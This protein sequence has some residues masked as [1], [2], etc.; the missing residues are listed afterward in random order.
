MPKSLLYRYQVNNVPL[1]LKPV[2]Y[3]YSYG[4]ALILFGYVLIFHLTSKIEVLGQERLEGRPNYIFC[5]WHTFIPLYFSAFYRNRS[6][7][8]MQHPFWFMKPIH[9]L[10]RFTGVEKIILGSTGHSGREAAD[11]LVE[12]LKKGYSTVLLPD[13]PNGPPFVLKKGILHI[14]L[15]SQ[16]PIVPMQFQA[17]KFV[18]INTWDRKKWPVPFSAVRVQLGNPIQVTKDNFDEASREITRALG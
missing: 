4:V 6:H 14:S 8:W 11:E 15:Q 9:L 7:V 12:Y 1:L 5:H 2:F 18:E 10:L 16:V 17:S 13:G 3:I